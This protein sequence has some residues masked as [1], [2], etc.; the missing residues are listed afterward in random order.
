MKKILH[1]FL[2]TFIIL[3][4][5]NSSNAQSEVYFREGFND[6]GGTIPSVASESL[7]KYVD[8]VSSGNWYVYGVYRTSGATGSCLT[9][10]GTL[11]HIRFANLNA[12]TV[13][14]DSAYLITPTVNF[15][16]NTITFLNGRASRRLTIYKTSDTAA[17]T[18]NW[19]SVIHIPA[20]NIACQSFTVT[21]NDATAKRLKIIA[22]SG[23]DSDLD[24]LVL[25]STT[26]I[27]PV[28]FTGLSAIETSGKIKVSWKIATE[29]NTSKYVIERSVNGISFTEIGSLSA[30][31]ASS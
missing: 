26:A 12:I 8:Q 25:T 17:L 23:T 20:T 24:S 21:I 2:F 28:T 27:L 6:G 16:I 11:S 4:I 30:T 13:A 14:N 9:E 5:A 29:L 1:S 22:R 15:G 18:T 10:T 7:G 31:N 19:T 3:L